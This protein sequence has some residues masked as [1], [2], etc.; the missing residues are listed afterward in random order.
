MRTIPY[1]RRVTIWSNP[2][3]A[4]NY[5]C[6]YIYIHKYIYIYIYYF[7][8]HFSEEKIS[9]PRNVEAHCDIRPPTTCSQGLA[10]PMPNKV[11]YVWNWAPGKGV[12][13]ISFLI[14]PKT[15]VVSSTMGALKSK[16]ES[17]RRTRGPEIHYIEMTDQ[18]LDL[19]PVRLGG[20]RCWPISIPRRR[21]AHG[22]PNPVFYIQETG[23]PRHLWTYLFIPWGAHSR[24]WIRLKTLAHSP[25]SEKWVGLKIGYPKFHPHDSSSKLWPKLGNI[26]TVPTAGKSP[27][28]GEAPEPAAARRSWWVFFRHFNRI[29]GVH[30]VPRFSSH[31]FVG[32][33]MSSIKKAK[34]R[35]W[36][37]IWINSSVYHGPNNRS[38]NQTIVSQ[39]H[40]IFQCLMLKSC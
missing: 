21:Q 16:D 15:A 11:F 17:N 18:F 8:I 13:I 40:L 2:P 36:K 27:R 30:R 7:W 29:H 35:L 26:Y 10:A 38:R 19:N 28:P 39:T 9:L 34:A 25:G 3:T 4:H 1:P 31:I 24:F 33:C 5:V 12:Y 32:L 6:M 37:N 14:E 20:S 23:K 22:R